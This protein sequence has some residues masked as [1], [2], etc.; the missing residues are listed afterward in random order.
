MTSNYSNLAAKTNLWQA[1]S[2]SPQAT[3]M[4]EKSLPLLKAWSKS[5]AR[6]IAPMRSSPEY[7]EELTVV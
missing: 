1:K 6:E 3:V 5:L 4:S 7:E 2:F